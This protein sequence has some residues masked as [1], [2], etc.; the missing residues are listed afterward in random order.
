MAK[1]KFNWEEFLNQDEKKAIHCESPREIQE[2]LNLLRVHG[3]KFKHPWDWYCYDI[4]QERLGF[5]NMTG[6]TSVDWYNKMGCKIYKFYAY[7][8]SD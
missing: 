4:P 6:F 3:I 5:S 2:C 1:K 8:F 7:D